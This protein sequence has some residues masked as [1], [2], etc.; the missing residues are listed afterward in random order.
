[1]ASRHGASLYATLLTAYFILLHRL[2]AQDHIAVGSPLPA[3]GA[4]WH[5][6][7]GSF[8]NPV[9]LQASFEPNIRVAG[10]LR[11]V[12]RT[13]FRALANQDYPLS[14]L[15]ERLNPPRDHT[16]HPYFQ[17]MFVFQNARGAADV[18]RLVAG[19][20]SHVPIRWGGC[21]VL[22]FWRPINGGAGFDLVFELAEVGENVVCDLEYATALFEPGT[23]GGISAIGGSCWKAWLP[24]T[25]R[26]L[27]GCRF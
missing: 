11:A 9:V 6:V 13:A 25:A 2:T 3:R 12:R 7:V 26:P 8:F 14:D 10:L 21:E 17:T 18:L 15:V 24:M 1:M 27:T 20:H 22:P 16:G 23:M 19:V 4:E 5:D